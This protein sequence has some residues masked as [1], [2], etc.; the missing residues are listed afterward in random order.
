M[1]EVGIKA[2]SVGQ[3]E[4]KKNLKTFSNW[5]DKKKLQVGEGNRTPGGT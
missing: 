1:F 4:K 5:M 3:D 2:L